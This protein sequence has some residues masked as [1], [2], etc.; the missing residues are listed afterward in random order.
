MTF[1]IRV[2]KAGKNALTSTDPNDFIFHSAYNTFKIIDED[3]LL[4]Q[5][6]DTNPKTLTVA[7]EQ[8]ST[9]VVFA[10]TK[11][12]DGIICL[13]NSFDYPYAYESGG[14]GGR[15]NIQVDATNIYFVFE[16]PGSTYSVDIKY[17]IFEAPAI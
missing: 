11:Y 17:Y 3:T 10:F 6:I 7:H 1:Q 9:P 12:P 2:A 5:S 14:V 15:F 13:P 16:K 8:N 4:S